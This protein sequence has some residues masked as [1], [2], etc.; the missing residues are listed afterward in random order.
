[1]AQRI[2]EHDPN[3]P[4][5]LSQHYKEEIKALLDDPGRFIEYRTMPAACGGTEHPWLVVCSGA[6]A[7]R[8][9]LDKKNWHM[10]YEYRVQPPGIH[11]WVAI[12]PRYGQTPE[13]GYSH[14][15]PTLAMDDTIVHNHVGYL[16]IELDP[17]NLPRARVLETL[18]VEK[19]QELVP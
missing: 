4:P 7:I 9:M 10:G 15:N 5:D 6:E 16:H 18:T 3:I 1:M 12:G 17:E 19:M 13:L 2:E 14:N 11:L 8:Y